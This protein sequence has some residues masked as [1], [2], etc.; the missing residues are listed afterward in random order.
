[1]RIATVAKWTAIILGGL[2]LLL[3][4]ALFVVT[5]VVDPNRYRPKIEGIV[6]DL[7]GRPF[8]I[9]GNLA[10]T[11][12]PWLGIRTGPAHLDNPPG[13]P[14][15]PTVEWQSIAIAAKVWPLLKGD[16]VV[17]RIRLQSPVIHLRRD[18]QG[19]GNWEGLGRRS[20]DAGTLVGPATRTTSKQADAGSGP[21]GRATAK[22]TDAG[23]GPSGS[24]TSANA[25][26]PS[27]PARQLQI[28]GI[29][30]RDGTVDYVD[31]ASG[32]HAILANVEL[33]VGE[34]RAGQS[35][36]VH[37]RFLTHMASLPPDGVWVQLDAPEL[38]IRPEPLK[39]AEPKLT[40]KVANALLDGD[41]TYE[42]T[43]AVRAHGS[44]VLRTDSLRKLANE[45]ALNQTLPHDPTTLGPLELATTWSY[46][47]GALEAKPLALKLDGVS[48]NGWLQRTAPP[49]AMWGFELRGDRIDLGRYVQVDSTNQKPFEFPAEAL[50]AIKANGSLIF[51]Q[52]VLADTHMTNVRLKLQTPEAKQ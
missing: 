21:A 9:E 22:K 15:P 32:Q 42:Q 26:A 24:A 51:D 40:L 38:A 34:W 14:G 50:R 45:L 46:N 11:W 37:T 30:I 44:V 19:R 23:S 47:D 49:E 43:P 27:S 25:P 33:D 16:V 28:A 48:F 31:E 12:Y 41:I 13:V 29:E 3:A 10:L 5:S 20:P 36:P 2:V 39:V 17:D 6:A 7:T 18:A 1:M 8:V 35:L 4:A 52:V